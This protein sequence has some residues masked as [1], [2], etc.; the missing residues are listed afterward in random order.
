MSCGGFADIA[1]YDAPS[2]L[3]YGRI[4]IASTLDGQGPNPFNSKCGGKIDEG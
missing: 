4:A 1:G 3:F 2:A